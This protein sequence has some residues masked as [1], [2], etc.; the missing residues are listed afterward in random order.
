MSEIALYNTL[1]KLGVEPD[2][3]ERAVADVASSKEVATKA[4]I[5]ALKSEFKAEIA[6]IKIELKYMRWVLGLIF[7]MNVAILIKL[8]S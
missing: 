8:F 5:V 3:A 2:E 6:K 1:T 7:V 4:D